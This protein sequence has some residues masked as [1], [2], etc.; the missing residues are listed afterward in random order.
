MSGAA[1]QALAFPISILH[2]RHKVQRG[3]GDSAVLL[4]FEFIEE[5]HSIRQPTPVRTALRP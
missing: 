1:K 5:N 3:D 2:K 4:I